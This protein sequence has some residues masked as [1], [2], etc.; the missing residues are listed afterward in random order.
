M[1]KFLGISLA[2]AAVLHAAPATLGEIEVEAKVDTEVVADVSGEEIKSADLGEALFKVSPSVSLVRRSGIANDII[3]RG[4]K[5]DNINV[6]IDG[7]KIFGACPNRMDPP[8]SHILTNNVDYIEINEGPYN[9]EDFGSLSADVKVHT[10]KPSKE[11]SGEAGLNFGSWGYNKQYFHVSGGEGN[12]R[13]LLS[14]SNENGGQYE[15]GDGNDFY[16][17][18]VAANAPMGNRYAPAYLGMDA[19][20]KKTVMAKLFWDIADNQELRLGY[21]AN[22]SDDILYPNTP[23]DA[24]YD[25]SDIY[26]AEYIIKNMGKYSKKLSL[27]LY[28]SEVDHPMSN[29]YRR[30]AGMM[31][32]MLAALKTKMQ[33]AKLKNEFEVDNHALTIGLDYSLRN[34][35]G[36]KYKDGVF[37][38]TMIADA[39]TRNIALFIKD[40]IT[41]DKWTVDLGARYDDTEAS[42]ANPMH[43]DNDYNTL[44]GHVLATYHKDETTDYFAGIGSSI[45]VPD[46]RELYYMMHG[47]PNLDEVRN[48]E[49]DFGLEKKYGNATVKAKAFYS[50]LDNFIIYNGTTFE[51]VDAKIWGAELSGT[52]I[53]TDSL[54]FDYGV[55]Y[56]RGTKR[57]AA[58]GVDKD[59]PEIPPLKVNLAMNYMYSDSLTFNAEMIAASK[60]K[61]FDGDNGEQPLDGYAVVNLKATKAFSKGFELTLGIDNL[62]DETYAV[63]N[64]YKDLTLIPTGAGDIMLLNEPGRYLYANLKYTF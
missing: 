54:T 37:Q 12:V 5:K 8:I 51:N 34:W 30:S 14:A 55:T 24:L 60:W 50:L 2:A 43:P 61:H 25:D 58:P 21:T 7:V 40:K 47:N 53:L 28:Q 4:Q 52:Y 18:Q 6:T 33:G 9:V 10:L 38:N 56:Q 41:F 36:A 16:E 17:Q 46:P 64:T 59:L 31:G 15:D 19:F 63:S 48:N 39:D 32:V 42:D 44:G 49:I 45:R 35:D 27:S 62:F 3:V 29:D 26:T 57:D 13:F 1:K 22:R 11:F 23:M 20:T